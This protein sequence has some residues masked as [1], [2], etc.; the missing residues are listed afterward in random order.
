[1]DQINRRSLLKTI[2]WLLAS[3]YA[4]MPEVM[5]ELLRVRDISEVA[6]ASSPAGPSW[7]HSAIF[8]QVYPQS[9]YDSDAD[10]VGD[11][12]GLI[13][14][15][16]YIRSLGCNALWLNPV[17][18]S[19]FGDGGYDV[20]DFF[21]VASRYGTEDDIR[22]L[23]SEAHRRGMRVCLDLVAGHTSVEHPWFRQ[24]MRA[25]RNEFSDWYIWM[26]ASESVPNS[27]AALEKPN[28]RT[29]SEHY[30]ANF[31][32]FQPALNYGYFKPDGS[33]PWQKSMNDPVCLAVQENLR[34]VMK[35]WLDLGV[36]GFRVDMASS[37]I[38]N[39]PDGEGIRQLWR[40]NRTWLD[41]HYPE[42]VLISEWGHPAESIRAGF[43]IDF[44]L[45]FGQP[46]Y[47]DLVGPRSTLIGESRRPDAFFERSGKGDITRFVHNYMANYMPTRDLG[48]I[49]LPTGN[50]DFPRPTWGRDEKDVRV[51]FA[52]LFTMPGVPFL[53][54]GDEIGMRFLEHAPEKEGANRAGLRAGSRTPMQWSTGKNAGFSEAPAG[55]LYL[56]IDPD[57]E[58]PNVETQEKEASSMLNFTRKLLQLRRE[59]PAL[60]NSGSFNARYAE[61]F[62]APFVYERIREGQHVIVAINPTSASSETQLPGIGTVKALLAQ[63]ASM[64]NGMLRMEPVSFGIFVILT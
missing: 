17:F 31:F 46:A 9:F 6:A 48:Y 58:R 16:D 35:F 14:K 54:Y 13:S 21:R 7:L 29:R 49:S 5:A 51:L 52:M 61:A 40:E 27:F 37:L 56:P 39:D 47:I 57:Q 30:L 34:R 23:A 2:P 11:L 32:S 41:K 25:D 38:R 28:S 18:D 33:K 64:T 3:S 22:A 62:K 10:G 20:A 50:H 1:M 45:H 8:Y 43:N 15:L 60:S 26:L 44:L 53:Y 36:D 55:D 24:A 19:P 59:I 63:G 12:I 4:N 42:A